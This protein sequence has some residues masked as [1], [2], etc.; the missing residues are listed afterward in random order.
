M[1]NAKGAIREYWLMYAEMFAIEAQYLAE[2]ES[3]FN[4]QGANIS[5][6][7]DRTGFLD[8]A[9]SKI[10]SRLDNEFKNVKQVMVMRGATSGDGSVDPAR[11]Q[12]GAIGAVGVSIHPAITPGILAYGNTLKR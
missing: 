5:L 2:G 12:K 4:Y 10:Q 11:L 6:D 8:S 1:L 3:A 7:V 9:A